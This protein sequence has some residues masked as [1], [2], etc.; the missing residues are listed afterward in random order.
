MFIRLNRKDPIE[1]FILNTVNLSPSQYFCG[2]LIYWFWNIEKEV[3]EEV[4]MKDNKRQN[5]GIQLLL[6]KYKEMFRIPENL[7]YYSK[8]DYKIAEKK[9]LKYALKERTV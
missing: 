3:Y 7:D 6:K 4:D 5:T 8:V 9:F 1:I 2:L